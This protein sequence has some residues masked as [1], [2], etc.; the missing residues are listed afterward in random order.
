[1]SIKR[2]DLNYILQHAKIETLK[3]L[4]KKIDEKLGV[5]VVSKPSSQTLLVPI[6]DP[7]LMYS[8][9]MLFFIF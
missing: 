2:E 8:F 3:K 4:Y 5:M 6:K 1:M 9:L 7:I